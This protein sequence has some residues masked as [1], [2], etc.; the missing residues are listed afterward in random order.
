MKS[1]WTSPNS[2]SAHCSASSERDDPATR[3]I[4][5]ICNQPSRDYGGTQERGRPF[6]PG[7]GVASETVAE[8][9]SPR[10]S[11]QVRARTVAGAPVLLLLLAP[12]VFLLKRPQIDANTTIGSE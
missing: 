12:W 4:P 3:F 2:A 5:C 8:Q 9:G 6:I 10:S 7:S 11:T 1:M